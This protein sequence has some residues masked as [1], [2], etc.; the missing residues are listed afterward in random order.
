MPK[1]G[2][3][4]PIDQ[5]RSV[6][7]PILVPATSQHSTQI[8]LTRLGKKLLLH[9]VSCEKNTVTYLKALQTQKLQLRGL[10]DNMP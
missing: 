5:R 6:Q 4:L 9:K 2:N 1:I 7:E 10:S 3:P 8:S